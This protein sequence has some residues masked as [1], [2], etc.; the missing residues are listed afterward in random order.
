M[1][2]PDQMW[3]STVLTRAGRAVLG[4]TIATT[5]GALGACSGEAPA[6]APSTAGAA[7]ASPGPSESP[8]QEAPSIADTFRAVRTAAL[9]AESAR[10]EG[11]LQR[12][13]KPLGLEVEGAADGSNQQLFL[14]VQDG[15]RPEVLTVGED[16]WLGGDEAFWAEQ[17]GDPAAGKSMVGTYVPIG[18]AD[19]EELGSF[20]LRSILTQKFAEPAF[21]AMETSTDAVRTDEVGGSPAYVL[22]GAG[23]AQ[24]WV[25]ADGSATLL[26]LVG[27]SDDPADLAFSLW[28]R[29]Q[30]FTP[31]PPSSVVE[32]G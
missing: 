31:P 8:S 32:E 30:T 6:P 29:A 21:S 10:I 22:D 25:A 14:T 5:L 28:D 19:A 7:T 18:K 9:S 4:L 11:T 12:Q 13:G 20:T 26:R 3:S 15:G 17:T 1:G 16:Y 27:S 24:L 23:G 2:A